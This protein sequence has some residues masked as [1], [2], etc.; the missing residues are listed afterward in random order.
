MAKNQITPT[1]EEKVL[2]END[3]IVSKTDKKGIITYCNEIFM[4]M[5]EYS[6]KE[7]LGQNH[8]IIR[9]PD[10]PRIAFKVA[11]DLIQKGNEF[12]G[13]VKNLRK[14]GGYYWVFA[15]ISP[16]YDSSGQIIGYTSIRRKPNPTALNTIIP[17]YKNLITAEKQSGMNGSYKII[18]N[19]L[20]EKNMQ[21]NE[22]IVALQG[23]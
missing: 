18:E 11:W 7:L 3:F 10:M 14:N 20:K 8:N 17:L 1:N 6:E 4:D 19:L 5:A 15:N 23:S 2:G 9:H 21:Y 12:F 16:D 22:L 13:F